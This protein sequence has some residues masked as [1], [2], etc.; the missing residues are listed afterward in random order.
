MNE[1]RRRIRRQNEFG[2]HLF[3]RSRTPLFVL[4]GLSSGS[5]Q[6][7][8]L[9]LS[10]VKDEDREEVV[11]GRTEKSLIFEFAEVDG[12]FC[13]RDD[14]LGGLMCVVEERIVVDAQVETEQA[15]ED[16][17]AYIGADRRGAS[18]RGA[19]GR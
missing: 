15:D 10:F 18:M 1:H 2:S 19:W 14:G 12:L 5:R 13:G 6:T 11:S 4:L 9:H 16:A 17:A 3:S 8:E 7:A